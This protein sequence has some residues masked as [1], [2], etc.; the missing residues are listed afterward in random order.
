MSIYWPPDPTTIDLTTP[1]LH[2]YIVGVGDYPFLRAGVANAANTNFGLQQ[3]TTTVLTGV[4]IAQW[5]ETEYTHPTVKLGSIELLL[6]APQ[7][8][9]RKD[10]Q[11]S[12][13]P[14]EAAT[15]EN[16]RRTFKS[17]E[18]GNWFERCNAHPGNIAL[19]YF[20]GHGLSAVSQYLLL[21]DFADPG[22]GALWDNCINFDGM[23]QGMR[24]NAADTQ[25]F[26]VD[27]CRETPID[28]LIQRNPTG[29]TLC[30]STVFDQ[31]A[32]SGV[33]YAA[34]EGL[35]AYGPPDDVTFFATAVLESLEGAGALQ[36]S[37]RWTVDTFMLGTGL[38]HVMNAL[39]AETNRPLSC[40]PNASGKPA[41]I[42][43]PTT[44]KV[45][46]SIGC[47]TAQANAESLITVNGPK[48]QFQSAIG[49]QRPW[50]QRIA[51]GRYDVTMQ[52]QTLAPITKADEQVGPTSYELKVPV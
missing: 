26:F 48:E 30:N 18:P 32:S 1:R 46:A 34:A 2:A 3:L 31:V 36:K 28:V 21:S 29:A 8:V 14:I 44:P 20:A 17:K 25:L 39:A 7:E 11:K 52:F 23:V 40:N 50:K 33:Y 38:G 43:C 35:Q 15:M 45:R 9:T 13:V 47:Q 41:A 16:V 4:R 10:E 42:H 24:S 19:F 27:A 6:S 5:F 37:G 22:A 49:E 51:P 12:V